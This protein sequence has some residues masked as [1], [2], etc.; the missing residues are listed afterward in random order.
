MTCAVLLAL[1]VLLACDER[2]P[3]AAP[4][5]SI[6]GA[7]ANDPCELLFPLQVEEVVGSRVKGEE[8]VVGHDRVTRI[9]FYETGKPWASVSV[10]LKADVSPEDFEEAMQRDPIN[11]EPVND[12]G[13]EAFI[14]ACASITVFANGVLV[15]ASVQH[16][17]TCDQTAVVLRKLG[18]AIADA[19]EVQ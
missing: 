15:S 12:V 11:S 7:D 5:P 18:T 6:L 17:T 8:E 16:L 19:L 1:L 3:S 14:H 9:C 10:S 13:E 2:G 4:D